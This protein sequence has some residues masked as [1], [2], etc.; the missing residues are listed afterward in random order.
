MRFLL[1]RQ[2]CSFTCNRWQVWQQLLILSGFLSMWEKLN[3][4]LKLLSFS[5]PPPLPHSIRL[6]SV[7]ARPYV[8]LTHSAI[9]AKPIQKWQL[10]M[11]IV[12]FTLIRMHASTAHC[13]LHYAVRAQIFAPIRE[14]VCHRQAGRYAPLQHESVAQA[15]RIHSNWTKNAV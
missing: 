6:P 3:K 15:N 8:H 12:I 13:Q 11:V 1:L 2:G 5:A 14:S 9:I 4:L 7:F 10:T